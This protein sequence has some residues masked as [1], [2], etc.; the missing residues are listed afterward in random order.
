MWKAFLCLLLVVAA[1]LLLTDAETAV[2]GPAEENPV[3]M[4]RFRAVCKELQAAEQAGR[5]PATIVR[6]RQELHDLIDQRLQGLGMHR[7]LPTQP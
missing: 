3:L 1:V 6:L 2:P 4:A 7:P 5:D